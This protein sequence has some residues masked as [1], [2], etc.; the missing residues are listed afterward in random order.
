M[1]LFGKFLALTFLFISLLFLQPVFAQEKYFF[2]D[3]FNEERPPNILNPD[4]WIAYPNKRLTPNQLGCFVDTINETGGVMRLKQCP[5]TPQFPYVVSKAN[6]FPEGDFTTTV[7]FKYVGTEGQ[8]NGIQF[9][10]TAPG[11]G[12][13]FTNLFG[14]GT[15]QEVFGNPS[16]P[17]LHLTYKH[18]HAASIPIFFGYHEFKAEKEGDIYKLYLDNKLYFTSPPTQERVGA[19]YFG[20]PS[21]QNP[22]YSW[23]QFWIDF[24]RISDDGPSIIAPEPFLDLPWDYDGDGLS[25]N[26]A[27]TSINSYFDHEYPLLSSGLTEPHNVISYRG[28]ESSAE[29]DYSSHDGYDYGIPAEVNFGKPVLAAGDGTAT[30]MSSCTACG[31]AILIDHGNGYQTRYYHMQEDGLIVSEPGQPV[32]VTQGR[33]IGKVGFSGNVSPSGETGSHLHFMVVQDK[34]GNG[35]FSD[36]IPDGMTDPF[37]WQSTDPDPW[38]NYTFEQGEE[39]KTGSRSYYLFTK[40][41][42]N[43]SESLTSNAKVFTVGKTKLEFPQG[44]TDQNLNLSIKSTPNFTNLSG[45]NSLGSIILVEAKN[46][47]GQLITNFAKNFGLTINFSQF[48]L[49]R[50]NLDT[51]SIYSS[52]DGQNWT[53]EQTQ[54]DLNNKTA[55]TSIS[56]LTYFALMAERKD[57]VAPT[58]TVNLQGQKGTNNNFRSDVSLSLTSQDNEGGLGVEF[59][60]YAIGETQ[61]QAY[62]TPLSFSAEGKYKIYFYS[63]D[64]DGNIEEIKSVEFSIDKT[65]PEAKVYID[66]DRMDLVVQGIDSSQTT[67]D[68]KDN[69]VTKKKDDAIYTVSD[70]AGNNLILDVRDRDKNK[71]DLFRIHSLKYNEDPPIILDQNFFNVS[72]QGKKERFS[73]KE[74][75]FKI[76]DEVKIKIHY[77]FKKDQS[78]IITK[79]VGLEKVKEIKEGLTLLQLIS[80]KGKLEYSY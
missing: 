40:Q 61:W 19:V 20:D 45:L 58:T 43:L 36:N 3:E 13:G 11:N 79:E 75:S 17:T 35:D 25:F 73:V 21:I 12:E 50:F 4:K 28:G 42:D 54:I 67:I 56:H 9:V 47:A 38:E 10:D 34:D 49:N 60:A 53:K 16:I 69:L 24:I 80:N 6:P 41:L 14:F 59:T 39:Q 31:N 78:T 70:L 74:Q 46:Q 29:L 26:E 68:K 52:P 72:Y 15:W 44:T 77:N 8:G 71:Q 65:I 30:Y 55:T 1:P 51:L 27:A 37:G 32:E 2:Q 23:N 22:Q 18:T 76:K 57:T 63:Q 64:K 5:L 33:E 62:T 7:R 48:D 66:L